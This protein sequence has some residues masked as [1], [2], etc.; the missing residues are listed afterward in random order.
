MLT[1]EDVERI[2]ENVLRDLTIVV[3]PGDFYSP[4]KRIVEL[5]LGSRV[6]SSDSFDVVSVRE[7]E[8]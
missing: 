1:R 6:I 3:K 7:Y 2:V 4:N 5:S 8:G